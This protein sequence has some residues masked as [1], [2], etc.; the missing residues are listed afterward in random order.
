MTVVNVSTTSTAGLDSV[1]VALVHL[2]E[3]QA[4]TGDTERDPADRILVSAES[5]A[6]RDDLETLYDRTD[7]RTRSS[8]TSL[9]SDAD[10]A[11][12]ISG[13]GLVVSLV[14]GSLFVATT[15]GLE[16][17]RDHHLWTTLSALGF[18][19]PTRALVILVQTSLMT[20]S[21]GVLGVVLGWVGIAVANAG[22]TRYVDA[23]T[24][25]VFR[26]DVALAGLAVTAGIV[27]FTGPYILWLTSRGTKR[28]GL[29]A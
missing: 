23:T 5:S 22:V 9:G 7:V 17:R 10:L 2:S 19:A 28:A 26:L 13:A 25:A 24:V 6:V 14:V 4:V 20:L 18:S 11:L 8:G 12:A 1:P 27:I 29:T 16:I 3:L 21:G 15:V